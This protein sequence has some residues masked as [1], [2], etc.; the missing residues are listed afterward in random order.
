MLT[1]LKEDNFFYRVNKNDLEEVLKLENLKI[2]DVRSKAEFEIEDTLHDAVNLS[3]SSE[4]FMEKIEEFDRSY[5][6]LVYCNNGRRSF[7]ALKKFNKLKF[8]NLYFLSEGINSV[9]SA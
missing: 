7:I 2:I 1:L 3:I 6:Y 4:E 9:F 8:K 5:P